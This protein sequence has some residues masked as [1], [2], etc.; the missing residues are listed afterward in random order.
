VRAGLVKRHYQGWR[1]NHHNRGAGREVVYTVTPDALAALR[2]G[3]Q[4]M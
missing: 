4:L 2:R 3:T 1:T